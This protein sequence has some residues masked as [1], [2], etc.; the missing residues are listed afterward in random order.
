M[1]EAA[2]K[3]RNVSARLMRCAKPTW[4]AFSEVMRT[5][6][7][8]AVIPMSLHGAHVW[9]AKLTAE[10]GPRLTGAS[11]SLVR[12][13]CKAYRTIP[14]VAALALALIAPIDL[15]IRELVEI[16]NIKRDC[17]VKR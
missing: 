10:N 12:R 3:I 8:G 9:D 1:K 7:T 11:N 17:P 14:T 2:N 16:D 13:I 4:G 6:V 5:L 15:Q